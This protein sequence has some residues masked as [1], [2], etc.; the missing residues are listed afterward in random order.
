ERVAQSKEG[1]ME[2]VPER[3]AKY[4]QIV[5]GP[6]SDD[7]KT[8]DVNTLVRL[9]P[10][11]A[12]R[13]WQRDLVLDIPP[14]WW[15]PWLHIRVCVSGHVRKCRPWFPF[16]TF[17]LVASGVSPIA[18]AKLAPQLGIDIL[19]P[20][21]RC[22]PICDGTVD[23][24]ERVCC[25]RELIV[26]DPRLDDLLKRLR[27][28]VDGPVG[29]PIPIPDPPPFELEQTALVRRAAPVLRNV[30]RVA[31]PIAGRLAMRALKQASQ[32][33]SGQPGDVPEKLRDDLR[34]MEQLPRAQLHEYVNARAYLWPF[35]CICS[36]RKVG[37]A[38]I[39]I[40]GTF[41]FCYYRPLQLTPIGRRCTTTYAYR[42]HQQI[43]GVDTVIYDGLARH[44]YFAGDEDAQLTTYLSSAR[45]CADAPPPPVDH[46]KPFVMLQ[47]VG[48][49]RTFELVSPPQNALFGLNNAALP[50]NA[51]LVYPPPPPRTAEWQPGDT[52]PYD[53]PWARTLSLRLYFHPGMR[54]L[55]AV[56]YRIS[57]AQADAQG[58][59]IGTPQPLTDPVSWDRWEYVSGVPHKVGEAL[60]PNAVVD[61]NGDTQA[62]LYRI[63]YWDGSKLWLTDQFHAA[64]DTSAIVDGK[65]LVIVEVFDANG[66]RL[67]P[68]GATGSGID[69]DFSLLRWDTEPATTP[70][71]FAALAHLFWA[72]NQVCY[73]DIEDLRMD[74]I[75]NTAECQF[76]DG[77]PNSLF[78]AGFRAFHKHGTN[79]AAGQS[80]MWY[81]HIWYHRG[82]N[83]PNVTTD[84]SGVNAP[85]TR[86][87]GPAATSTAQTFATMLGNH[88]KCTFAL[89]LRVYAK[90]T[91]GDNSID[92]GAIDQAA[93]ALE[94]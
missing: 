91:N 63:P 62:G 69:R 67:R 57:I 74:G 17:D 61:A 44:E 41:T 76:M 6:A 59:P 9:R 53:R 81:Y 14:H 55:G 15:G 16:P 85:L 33:D 60:G 10:A 42:V 28:I 3:L 56:F 18:A 84:T 40:D 87:L 13:E 43:N 58:N 38:T 68:T 35:F 51:G 80:F 31:A 66:N 23:V 48:G 77:N 65:R 75:A 37:T 46:D 73:G 52:Q 88:Q 39:Q 47:D 29:G 89:N 19:R 21:F 22:R 12:L 79:L 64:W 11:D 30:A 86:D 5:L 25:C 7:P 1:R 32:V 82:L 26:F 72:N 4:D 24:Y 34:I 83:G 54:L 20:L 45:D 71:P 92:L 36:L 94:Q 50:A 27:E 90:H 8:L 70:V 93:F 2:I 78:S 49:T